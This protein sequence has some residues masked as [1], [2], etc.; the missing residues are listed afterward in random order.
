MTEQGLKEMRDRI[1]THLTTGGTAEPMAA[2]DKLY[3]D[4]VSFG[5][6]LGEFDAIKADLKTAGTVAEVPAAPAANE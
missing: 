4:R 5:L 2:F 3:P 6:F 1:R